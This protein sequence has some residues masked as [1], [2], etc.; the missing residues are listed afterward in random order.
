MFDEKLDLQVLDDSE[1]AEINGGVNYMSSSLS[2]LKN[3]FERACRRKN[4]NKIMEIL[5]ELQAR[6]EYSWA[7]DTANRY[8]ILSI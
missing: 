5:P 1:L 4:M 3:V 6:G 7:K 2:S 8:G